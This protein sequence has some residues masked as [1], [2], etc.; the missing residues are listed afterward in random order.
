MTAV[1][2]TIHCFGCRYSFEGAVEVL[3]IALDDEDRPDN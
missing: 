1:S 2:A 3:R